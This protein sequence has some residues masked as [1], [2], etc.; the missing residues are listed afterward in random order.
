MIFK[1]EENQLGF[2][3]FLTWR[4]RLE[5]R[6]TFFAISLR[7]TDCEI[8]LNFRA[9]KQ[10]PNDITQN[11][12]SPFCFVTPH[13]PQLTNFPA[14][15]FNR[16]VRG[17]PES[18]KPPRTNLC[19]IPD[20]RWPKSRNLLWSLPGLRPFRALGVILELWDLQNEENEAL[21]AQ[22]VYFCIFRC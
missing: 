6:I 14:R 1:I 11:R 19:S 21:G 10:A 20:S 18:G 2:Q 16:G 5:P 9:V 15:P 13:T 7:K 8:W 4:K 17:G 22:N 3:H 12:L